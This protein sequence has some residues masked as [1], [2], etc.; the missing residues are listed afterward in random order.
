MPSTSKGLR[1][2]AST[3]A[4]NVPQ[5][6]QNLASDVDAELFVNGGASGA[7]AGTAP[8][9]GQPLIVKVFAGSL[10]FNASGDQTV[11]FPGGAFPNGVVAVYATY[12]AAGNPANNHEF[13]PW[14]ATLS[15][16]NLRTYL[17]TAVNGSITALVTITAIGW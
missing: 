11:T 2:P 8:T 12:Y 5:D 9:A 4:P 7:M 15:T 1:Y 13:I 16:V 17:G 10:T 3:A 14:G 6:I